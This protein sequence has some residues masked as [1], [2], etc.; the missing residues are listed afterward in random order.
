MIS[1]SS[2]ELYRERVGSKDLSKVAKG[3]ADLFVRD[4]ESNESAFLGLYRNSSAFAL[5]EVPLN[6][7][8]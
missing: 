2:E 6:G 8:E 1:S 7:H 5:E 4:V 3:L